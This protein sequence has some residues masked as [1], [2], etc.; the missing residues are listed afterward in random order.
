MGYYVETPMNWGK[1]RYIA[2]TWGGEIVS[3]EVAAVS[4]KVST[5]GVI[6][7]VDNGPFE[8]AGFAYDEGQFERM[9]DRSR[10]DNRPRQWVVLERVVAEEISGYKT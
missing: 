6:C 2:E 3:E 7:V 10:G 1:A 8:A 5:L 4:V 9:R